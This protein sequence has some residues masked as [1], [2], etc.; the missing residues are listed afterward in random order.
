MTD[1]AALDV[2]EPGSGGA[3]RSLLPEHAEHPPVPLF[4]S[5]LDGWNS[6]T[7]FWLAVS[8]AG[9]VGLQVAPTLLLAHGPGPAV[10][11]FAAVALAV[12]VVIVRRDR[13]VALLERWFGD[14]R[15]H[16]TER[17]RRRY[18]AG[19]VSHPIRRRY[20]PGVR[21]N[22]FL[23]VLA[24]TGFTV[25]CLATG[26]WGGGLLALAPG[27]AAAYLTVRFVRAGAHGRVELSWDPGTFAPGRAA[28][29]YVGTSAGAAELVAAR[30]VLRRIR[31]RGGVQSC[32]AC[33]PAQLSCD[34]APDR[35]AR[36]RFDVPHVHAGDGDGV[37]DRVRWE[38]VLSAQVGGRPWA[39]VFDLAVPGP[40][41]AVER[42][43]TTPQRS[44][45]K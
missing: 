44:D 36:V 21:V 2:P 15:E 5:S 10:V 18:L 29:A 22:H 9:Y 16:A 25:G 11:A 3:A 35:A 6:R 26:G 28:E 42:A 32:T 43:D 19:P 37:A 41:A 39:D 1:G 14:G 31:V 8:L 12:T 45:A 27:C 34:P 33:V 13:I 38:L 23:I 20:D 17:Q 4:V 24:A 7:V 30:A 40:A